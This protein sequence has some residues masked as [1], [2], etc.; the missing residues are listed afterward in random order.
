MVY[1]ADYGSCVRT[2]YLHACA[3]AT[4]ALIRL[5]CSC[6][7]KHLI[8]SVTTQGF[9]S[10]LLGELY[11]KGKGPFGQ[12]GV[13]LG[14]PL[15]TEYAGVALAVWVRSSLSACQCCALLLLKMPA[16]HP[17]SCAASSPL[18]GWLLLVECIHEIGI[19]SYAV[20]VCRWASF[21]LQPLALET[22]AS[23]RATRRS[24]EK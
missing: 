5:S 7:S 18:C 12:I 11:T 17:V 16:C 15:N 1:M 13:P 22:L 21:S 4:L 9:A 19:R 2:Q 14:Q 23:K 24:T 6:S 10:E 20:S 8:S 3:S